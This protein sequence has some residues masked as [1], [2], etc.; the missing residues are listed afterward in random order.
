MASGQDLVLGCWGQPRTAKQL[1]QR[2]VLAAGPHSG[3]RRMPPLLPHPHLNE[4]LLSTCC[5]S[6]RG[7]G[8]GVSSPSPRLAQL[9][10]W[11]GGQVFFPRDLCAQALC[12]PAWGPPVSLG[13]PGGSL[14]RGVL[15]MEPRSGVLGSQ[16]VPHPIRF[17]ASVP[18]SVL[19]LLCDPC[20]LALT[21]QSSSPWWMRA[22]AVRQ[23]WAGVAA[24]SPDCCW[25]ASS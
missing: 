22:Q 13:Q 20:P 15:C 6:V 16:G 9:G 23:P 1:W 8:S 4:Y 11:W 25:Q 24:P 10:H 19:S 7:Q 21:L 17:W 12:P 3:T 2:A 5:V 14:A 18:S